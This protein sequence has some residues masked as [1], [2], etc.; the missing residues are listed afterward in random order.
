[1]NSGKDI[2]AEDRAKE[3]PDACLD[4]KDKILSHRVGGCLC[5]RVHVLSS[6]TYVYVRILVFCKG[7]GV[8]PEQVNSLCNGE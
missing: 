7:I 1:M 3:S 5:G 6:L 2:Q 8:L 4:L